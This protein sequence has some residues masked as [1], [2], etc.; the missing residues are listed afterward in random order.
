VY[1]AS[2]PNEIERTQPVRATKFCVLAE[3]AQFTVIYGSKNHRRV[4]AMKLSVLGE[5]AEL[6]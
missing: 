5:D 6:N 2:N 3:Y 1:L 4:R